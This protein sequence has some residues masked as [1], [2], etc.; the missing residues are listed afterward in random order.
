MLERDDIYGTSPSSYDSSLDE[1]HSPTR[2]SKQPKQP[3]QCPA[4]SEPRVLTREADSARYFSFPSFD[5]W[6]MDQ[7]DE[8][9]E[10]PKSP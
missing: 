8:K 9:E 3:D 5:T 7:Q 10:S 1:Y 4:T 2:K 6:E